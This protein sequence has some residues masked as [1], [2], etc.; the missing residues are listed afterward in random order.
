M[1]SSFS[2]IHYSK[3]FLKNYF[4]LYFKWIAAKVNFSLSENET[5]QISG[6]VTI[7]A[8]V[9][10][11]VELKFYITDDGKSEPKYIILKRPTNFLFDN[12][13]GIARWTPTNDTS[14]EIR[15]VLLQ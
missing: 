12:Q 10:K 4:L 8:E 3:N 15:F 11:T 9:N 14:A 13:T 1:P 2:A 5:P 7:N 6:N